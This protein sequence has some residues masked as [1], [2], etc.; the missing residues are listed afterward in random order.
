MRH[1]LCQAL[2]LFP[3]LISL[4]TN[5]AV[6]NTLSDSSNISLQ[7]IVSESVSAQRC[8]F[9]FSSNVMGLL[10]KSSSGCGYSSEKLLAKARELTSKKITQFDSMQIVTLTVTAP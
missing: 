6:A 5:V 10:N 2:F 1:S 7:V 8:G 9:D 4:L 3:L